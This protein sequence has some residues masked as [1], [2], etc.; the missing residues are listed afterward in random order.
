MCFPKCRRLA[1]LSPKLAPLAPNQTPQG[2][3]WAAVCGWGAKTTPSR[4]RAGGK[5]LLA[6]LFDLRSVDLRGPSRIQRVLGRNAEEPVNV[7]EETAPQPTRG[8]QTR[9][10]IGRNDIRVRFRSLSQIRLEEP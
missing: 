5:A 9:V 2:K 10:T 3:P 8:E 7:I 1:V 6:V 4:T